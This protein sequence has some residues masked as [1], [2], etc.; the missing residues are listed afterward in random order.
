[1]QLLSG[2]TAGSVFFLAL[3]LAS[4][5]FLALFLV[6]RLITPDANQC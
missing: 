6:L 4:A 2:C 3:F 1:M 5:L